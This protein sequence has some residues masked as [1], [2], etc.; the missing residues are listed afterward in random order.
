MSLDDLLFLYRPCLEDN[1]AESAIFGTSTLG[2]ST[3]DS[4]MEVYRRADHIDPSL[5]THH[6]LYGSSSSII[7]VRRENQ[8]TVKIRNID[9]HYPINLSSLTRQDSPPPQKKRTSILGSFVSF[10]EI[11]MVG[12]LLPG[13]LPLKPTIESEKIAN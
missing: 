2:S 4:V 9:D 7:K 8:S 6:F 11:V 3:F 12:V 13:F 1:Q 5:S 10:D